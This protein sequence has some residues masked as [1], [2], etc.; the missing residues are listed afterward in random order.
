MK[1]TGRVVTFPDGSIDAASTQAR[2]A[3]DGNP[4]YAHAQEMAGMRPIP[5]AATAAVSETLREQTAEPGAVNFASARTANEVMKAQ[6]RRIRLQKLKGE[7][8]DRAA[9]TSL[10]FR[11]A[12]QERDAWVGWP[13]RVAALMASEVGI[14]AH[15]MQTILDRYV[16]EQLQALAA[17]KPE[18]R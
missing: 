17:I 6:E 15:E 5:A 7:V 14:T 2:R 9:A 12:R 18:F 13:A 8:V 4:A 3:A 11:L 1:R 10:V 16:R